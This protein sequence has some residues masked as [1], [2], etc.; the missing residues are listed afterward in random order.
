L[1][2]A[3]SSWQRSSILKT[4]FQ[5]YWLNPEE[6]AARLQWTRDFFSDLYSQHG[7][8]R[9]AGT[10]YPSKRYEGCYINYPDSDMLAYD[11]WPQLYYGEDLYPFLQKV[12]Q[13][14]DPN[15]VFHHA[16]SVRA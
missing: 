14:Y 10:P 11:F 12:K 5:H 9:Y 1:G 4:Q 15:N 16:M 7:E 13:R 2:E 3:T 6:D 8:P